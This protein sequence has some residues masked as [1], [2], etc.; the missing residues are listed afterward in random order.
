MSDIQ[1]WED[2]E[3][4]LVDQTGVEPKIKGDE[5]IHTCPFCDKP[6]HFYVNYEKGV[7][8][9]YRCGGDDTDGS[10]KIE[11]LAKIL[12]VTVETDDLDVT[13]AQTVEQLD[14]DLAGIY[15]AGEGI[16]PT[17]QVTFDRNE[18]P[19]AAPVGMKFI[20]VTTWYQPEVQCAVAYLQSRGINGSHLYNYRLGVCTQRNHVKVVFTDFNRYGQLRWWQLRGVQFAGAPEQGGPKYLG[21]DGDKAGKIGNW[22]QAIQQPVD[23]IGVCEGPI[24]GIVAGLEFTWLW[25][26]EHSPEQLEVLLSTDKL[27]AIAMD[28]ESKA[29]KNALGLANDIRSGGGNA[30]IIPTPGDH[31]PASLGAEK[32]RA[33]LAQ[34]LASRDQND[35]DFLERVVQDYV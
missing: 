2:I 5:H 31:D 22:Y 25:G 13:R 18:V 33:V 21:P 26:K 4:A 8:N 14:N 17:G 6:F 1:N 28:G 15:I 16:V 29:F 11:K 12:G 3:N 19:I 20:D 7:Y 30:I 10:G 32:F 9:C 24:S 35:L 27:I 23:Y 34:T